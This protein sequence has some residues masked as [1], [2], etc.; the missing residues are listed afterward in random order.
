[1]RHHGQLSLKKENA[2]GHNL[3]LGIYF[4]F[5]RNFTFF[6]VGRSQSGEQRQGS[7][8]GFKHIVGRKTQLF[9]TLFIGQPLTLPGYAKMAIRV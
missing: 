4:A 3:L 8:N 7:H 9:T 1:M 5:M 2:P 6:V